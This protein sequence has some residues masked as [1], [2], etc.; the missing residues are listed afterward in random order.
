LPVLRLVLVKVFAGDIV[1][2]HFVGVDFAFL[3]GVFHSLNDFGFEGVSLFEEFVHAFG[4]G[5]GAI[6]EPL[7]VS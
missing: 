3:V 1:F 5:I 4:I 6:G 7:Q 2:R